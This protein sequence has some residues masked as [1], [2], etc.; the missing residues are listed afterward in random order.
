[1]NQF[2]SGSRTRTRKEFKKQKNHLLLN[3]KE[4]E[5]ALS[6]KKKKERAVLEGFFEKSR[7]RSVAC[8]ALSTAR[9][10]LYGPAA[11]SPAYIR[12][13]VDFSISVSVA[14]LFRKTFAELM[15]S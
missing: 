4:N 14:E 8:S 9:L 5:A 7:A 13:R 11:L 10:P 1:M 15:A 12:I 2:A 3:N 6:K